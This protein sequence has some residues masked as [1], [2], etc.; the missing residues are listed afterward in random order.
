MPSTV[1]EVQKQK[2]MN[3]GIVPRAGEDGALSEDV[4]ISKSSTR[5]GLR[6]GRLSSHLRSPLPLFEPVGKPEI[7]ENLAL[8]GEG[9]ISAAH[10]SLG[11]HE[12]PWGLAWQIE[13]NYEV[14]CNANSLHLHPK[15]FSSLLLCLALSSG[16]P[17]WRAPPNRANTISKPCT[18]MN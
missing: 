7:S 18:W 12:H 16:I 10:V 9:K 4:L 13:G 8:K 6:S 3:W 5:L 14:L 11:G 17:P 15:D 1:P 2:S